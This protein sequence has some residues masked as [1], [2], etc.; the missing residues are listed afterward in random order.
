MFLFGKSNGDI[1]TKPHV[2]FCILQP[3]AERDKAGSEPSIMEDE[4]W[5][6]V[7]KAILVFEQISDFFLW[8]QARKKNLSTYCSHWVSSSSMFL[9]RFSTRIYPAKPSLH[10]FFS[11][12]HLHTYWVSGR[13]WGA[14]GWEDRW[15]PWSR[16]ADVPQEEKAD[17]QGSKLHQEDTY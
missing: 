8:Y 17:G 12:K 4:G 15:S 10:A 2:V 14:R 16:G 3:S 1:K 9:H 11:H 6:Q 5:A 13:V 7:Q